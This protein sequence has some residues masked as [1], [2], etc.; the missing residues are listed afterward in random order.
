MNMTDCLISY[1]DT[2]SNNGT[3]LLLIFCISV[4]VVSST[5]SKTNAN[6][7]TDAVR[8]V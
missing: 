6:H 3:A 1:E 7:Y 2:N 4:I 8:N 5:M